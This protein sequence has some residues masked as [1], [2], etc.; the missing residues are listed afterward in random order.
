M[1]RSYVTEG[2][3]A[4][5]ALQYVLAACQ[6]AE[7]YDAF[8]D[9]EHAALW[10]GRADRGAKAVDAQCW[11]EAKGLYA[12]TPEKKSFSQH[13]NSLAVVSRTASGER[14]RGVA[15][16]ILDDA[17]LTQC[18]FYFRFYVVRAMALAGLGDRYVAELKPWRDMLA[19]GLTTFAEK[20]E[21]AR[22]DCHAWSACPNYDF[23]AV[24]C[25]IAPDAPGFRRVRI[26]PALGP[27]E[28]AEGRMPHPDGEV[29]VRLDRKPGGGLGASVT[30][31]SGVMGVFAWNGEERQL[32]P[33]QQ[34]LTFAGRV[35]MQK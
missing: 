9:T 32:A 21:P 31:P 24:V 28:W 11:V 25:G 23:L 20:P 19:L 1:R 8:G 27:L 10:R 17:S 34:D 30:L 15:A 29:A 2:G 35:E 12:D 6:A 13:V 14:A 3:S 26:A 22:S 18:T 5:I 16:K 7:L 33:G 4:F